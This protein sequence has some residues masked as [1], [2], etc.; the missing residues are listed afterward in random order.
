MEKGS[1]IVDMPRRR[2]TLKSRRRRRNTK[3]RCSRRTQHGGYGFM[4]REKEIV[5]Y[6]NDEGAAI[7]GE[8][9]ETY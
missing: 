3:R 4:P 6:F 8:A 1:F 9:P 5:Q 7:M 2:S